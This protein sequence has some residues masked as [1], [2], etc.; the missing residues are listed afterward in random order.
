MRIYVEQADIDN[1]ELSDRPGELLRTECPVRRAVGRQLRV[2]DAEV[3]MEV[4]QRLHGMEPF[5][6][7]L[8]E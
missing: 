7:D 1:F 2:D 4:F 6:F 3:P 5:H 8:R